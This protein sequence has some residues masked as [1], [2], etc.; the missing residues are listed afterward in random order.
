VTEEAVVR[1][2]QGRR[3]EIIRYFQGPGGDDGSV[4]ERRLSAYEHWIARPT[5]AC[6]WLEWV[7]PSAATRLSGTRTG[8]LRVFNKHYCLN[9]DVCPLLGFC[10]VFVFATTA[11][12]PDGL[13]DLLACV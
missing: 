11:D 7:L 5:Q 2:N 6:L 13:L 3:I 8:G 4:G 9:E 12:F 10:D 1:V